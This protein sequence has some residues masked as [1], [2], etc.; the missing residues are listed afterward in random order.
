MP[1]PRA[2]VRRRAT[3]GARPRASP[4]R[5]V[6]EITPLWVRSLAGWP[7]VLPSCASREELEQM[8]TADS[9]GVHGLVNS[10]VRGFTAAMR[11]QA[12]PA[13]WALDAKAV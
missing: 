11:A 12:W 6:R 5:E 2:A 4:A 10:G 9:F 3:P 13:Q 7:V 8:L 1:P